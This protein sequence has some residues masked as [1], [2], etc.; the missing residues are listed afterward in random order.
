[1]T[2]PLD[3]VRVIGYGDPL[4]ANTPVYRVRYEDRY[5][6]DTPGTTDHAEALDWA[7]WLSDYRAGRTDWSERPWAAQE[8]ELDALRR[9][10]NADSDPAYVA[11]DGNRYGTKQEHDLIWKEE[12]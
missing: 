3:T 9:Q 6:G 5:C 4:G 11:A 8:A 2:I 10:W 7:A 1:M 12:R